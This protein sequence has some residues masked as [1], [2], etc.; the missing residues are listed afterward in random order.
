M[1]PDF[2]RPENEGIG[3]QLEEPSYVAS[4]LGNVAVSDTVYPCCLQAFI[5]VVH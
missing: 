3:G 5:T 1:K 2:M 4:S